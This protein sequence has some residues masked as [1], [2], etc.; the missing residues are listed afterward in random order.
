MSV[1]DILLQKELITKDAIREVRKQTASGS[2]LDD[3]LMA[4]GVKPDDI[5]AARGE[6]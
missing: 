6:F 4:Q 2:S 3:A 5:I 1:L